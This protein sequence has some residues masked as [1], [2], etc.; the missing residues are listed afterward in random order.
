MEQGSVI[1]VDGDQMRAVDPR[2]LQ[3]DGRCALLE[4]DEGFQA[5]P[6]PVG[7][8]RSR[9]VPGRDRPDALESRGDGFLNGHG[10]PPVLEAA[11]GVLG[12]VLGENAGQPDLRPQTIQRE[13]GGIA[14][15]ETELGVEGG[16][17]QEIEELLDRR[18]GALPDGPSPG[19]FRAG[20]EERL[21]AA[22]AKG[23][24]RVADIDRPAGQ[25]LE[26]VH[27]SLLSRLPRNYRP[28]APGKE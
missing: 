25:A 14:L 4:Q 22:G 7:R 26:R 21:S 10:R 12:F 1:P 2:R 28:Y 11:G 16:E 9:H 8:R 27:P 15:A 20:H 5:G 18:P 6:G 24:E 17:G 3:G 23:R 19:A 13:E